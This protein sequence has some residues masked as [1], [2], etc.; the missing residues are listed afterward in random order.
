MARV[1]VCR[2]LQEG[3]KIESVFFPLHRL[4]KVRG[5]MYNIMI[6]ID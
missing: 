5:R 6:I 4:G 3:S 1:Q 2:L